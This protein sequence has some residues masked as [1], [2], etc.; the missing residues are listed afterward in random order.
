MNLELRE[1]TLVT[2]NDELVAL[3]LAVGASPVS[4]SMSMSV[5][6]YSH[7]YSHVH[8]VTWV[9]PYPCSI[10]P[11]P[12]RA[13]RW[14]GVTQGSSSGPSGERKVRWVWIPHHHHHLF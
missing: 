8:L 14:S 11:T 4:M 7:V 2:A 1:R 3:A 9:C 12:A 6:T 10:M 13:T 5:S